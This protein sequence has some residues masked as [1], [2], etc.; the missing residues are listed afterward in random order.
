MW[1]LGTA[2]RSDHVAQMVYECSIDSSVIRI[3]R[4]TVLACES[5]GKHLFSD[6]IERY[7]FITV[8][9]KFPPSFV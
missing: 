1:H 5:V 9:F 3:T 6:F 2:G 4:A 8:H 7:N